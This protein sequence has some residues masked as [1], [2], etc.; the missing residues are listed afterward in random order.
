M[1]QLSQRNLPETATPAAVARPLAELARIQPHAADADIGAHEIV[2]CVPGPDNTP[3]VRAFGPYAAD[4]KSLASG[5]QPTRLQPF[6]N[7]EI[8]AFC[9][10]FYMI[11]RSDK[12]P[13]AIYYKSLF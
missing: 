3:I 13:L 1:S 8:L 9:L 4:L 11:R 12:I 2:V 5:S 10:S 6:V 7:C